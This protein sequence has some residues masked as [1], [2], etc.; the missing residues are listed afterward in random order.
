MAKTAKQDVEE[1]LKQLEREGKFEERKALLKEIKETDQELAELEVNLMDNFIFLGGIA[2][3]ILITI[4][5]KKLLE[6]YFK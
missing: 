5:T 2:I 1:I 4:G 3:G 6:N